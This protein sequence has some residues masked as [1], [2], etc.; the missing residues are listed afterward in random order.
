MIVVREQKLKVLFNVYIFTCVDHLK[1]SLN[2]YNI[3]V[4]L[5]ISNC[6]QKLLFFIYI[7]MDDDLLKFNVVSS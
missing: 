7:Y 1:D 6:S 5:K 2:L 4:S 3:F